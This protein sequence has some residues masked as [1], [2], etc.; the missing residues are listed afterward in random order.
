MLEPINVS[1]ESLNL[2]TLAPMLIPIVGALLILVVDIAKANLDKSLYVML[3]ILFLFMDFMSLAGSAS[4]FVQNGTILGLFDVMLIDGLAI[5]SQFII[6]IASMLSRSSPPLAA[7]R[8]TSGF[9]VSSR[10]R[11]ISEVRP[12]RIALSSRVRSSR[13]ETVSF[14]RLPMCSST[15]AKVWAIVSA[16]ETRRACVVESC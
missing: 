10:M 14:V 9:A 11:D 7:K 15:E 6:V 13:F 8:S 3:A 5:V 4:G 1:M 2:M 12:A 16:V